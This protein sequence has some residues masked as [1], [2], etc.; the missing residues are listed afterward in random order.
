MNDDSSEFLREGADDLTLRAGR[1]RHAHKAC[2][3]V[4]HIDD[5]VWRSPLVDAGWARFLPSNLERNWRK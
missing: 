3:T 4:D 1:I 2:I 5:K